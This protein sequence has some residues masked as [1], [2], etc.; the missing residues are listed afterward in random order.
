MLAEKPGH[1]T[2]LPS[3]PQTSVGAALK[4][5]LLLLPTLHERSHGHLFLRIVAM[6]NSITA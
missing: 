4:L 3:R 2:I 6:T 1:A 5:A